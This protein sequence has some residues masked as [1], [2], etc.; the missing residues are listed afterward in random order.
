MGTS[1]PEFLQAEDPASS[2]LGIVS[3]CRVPPYGPDGTRC[4]TRGNSVC[5]PALTFTD[6]A[7]WL[8]EPSVH[9][10]MPILGEERLP[11]HAIPAERHGGLLYKRTAEQKRD[12]GNF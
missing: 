4:K 8:V 3:H 11:Y 9:L 7:C 12:L 5:L 10:L 1:H 6:L 2:D